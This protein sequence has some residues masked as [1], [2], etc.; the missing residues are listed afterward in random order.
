MVSC[1]EPHESIQN[2]N[3]SLGVVEI[4]SHALS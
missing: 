1:H 4:F 3:I 2:L